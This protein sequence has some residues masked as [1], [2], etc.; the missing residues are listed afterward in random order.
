MTLSQSQAIHKLRELHDLKCLMRDGIELSTDVYM[1][2]TGGPF[3]TLLMRTP[4]D[5]HD[6]AG[7]LP[8][9][10][11]QAQRGYAVV[12]QDVRGWYDSPGDWY[13]FINEANDG[14]DAIEWAAK[15][16]WSTGKV[17][18]IG[19]LLLRAYTVAGRPGEQLPPDCLGTQGR[20]LKCLP[21]LGLYRRGL[22]A[23][24]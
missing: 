12:V 8:D 14:H 22:S 4:Y 10:I 15:Q 9:A 3:P 6:G 23:G 20:L 24:F 13:P 16:P 1:P 7:V 5:N 17:G 19:K 11:Y 18:T 21:Q 2:A